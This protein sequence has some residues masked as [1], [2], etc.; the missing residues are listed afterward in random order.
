MFLM[1]CSCEKSILRKNPVLPIEKFPSLVEPRN[2]Y[3]NVATP[4]YPIH[5][6]LSVKWSLAGD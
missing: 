5:P 3:S 2:A 6:L 4:Y 1:F